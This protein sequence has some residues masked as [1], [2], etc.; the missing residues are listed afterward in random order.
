MTAEVLQVKR[1]GARALQR[2]G[3]QAVLLSEVEGDPEERIALSIDEF[4]RVLGGG[5]VPGSVVLIGGDPGI[6]KST[7]LLQT[8]MMASVHNSVLYVSGEES[9]RQIKLRSGRLDA[10]KASQPISTCYQKRI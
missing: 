8:A 2:A 10:G 9:E 3:A 6:G 5:I 7:L 4:A 1:G